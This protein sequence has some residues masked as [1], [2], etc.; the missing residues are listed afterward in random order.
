MAASNN[1]LITGDNEEESFLNTDRVVS[2]VNLLQKFNTKL[3]EMKS[4]EENE[5]ENDQAVQ[6]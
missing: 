3:W 6:V 5:A 2:I 4:I 1:Q